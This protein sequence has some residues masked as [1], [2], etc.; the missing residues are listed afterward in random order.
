MDSDSDSDGS[1]CNVVTIDKEFCEEILLEPHLRSKNLY[2]A[3]FSAQAPLSLDSPRTSEN[4]DHDQSWPDLQTKQPLNS[5]WTLP[6]CLQNS[7]VHTF[8]G[9]PRGKNNSETPHISDSSMP[10]SV[11]MLYVAEIG[12]LFVAKTNRY[13]HCCMDTLDN[14]YSPQPDATEAEML[15]FLAITIQTKYCL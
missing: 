12:T 11:F 6:S 8:T 10:L 3:C 15:V 5:Q 7:A 2:T 1:L 9:G 4:D 13:Y 14:G